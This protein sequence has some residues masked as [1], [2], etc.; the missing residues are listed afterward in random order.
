MAP[1][2]TNCD[3][4]TRGSKDAQRIARYADL[5]LVICVLGV[6]CESEIGHKPLDIVLS[7]ATGEFSTPEFRIEAAN[8][9]KI[10]VGVQAMR[11]S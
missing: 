2:K 6:G 5:S 4:L 7:P 10:S 3:V 9:Y 8:K 11:T 1:M